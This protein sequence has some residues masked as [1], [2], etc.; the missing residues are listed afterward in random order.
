MT[1][2]QI[3]A[4]DPT[5]LEALKRLVEQREKQLYH[6]MWWTHEQIDDYLYIV[7]FQDG[8]FI[9]FCK[10]ADAYRRYLQDG[11]MIERKTKDLFPKREILERKN[12]EQERIRH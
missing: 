8:S 10:G 6:E 2:E 3:F 12:H 4:L 9:Y 11:V 5:Q 7:H 1:Q